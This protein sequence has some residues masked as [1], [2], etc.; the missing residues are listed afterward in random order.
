M[1]LYNEH[2]EHY[3]EIHDAGLVMQEMDPEPAPDDDD[4]SR[5]A[6]LVS[7]DLLQAHRDAQVSPRVAACN[8]LHQLS[9]IASG[10]DALQD[11]FDQQAAGM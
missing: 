6:A 2:C 5:W 9:R 7:P 10:R 1:L 4:T 11:P 3:G 8:C